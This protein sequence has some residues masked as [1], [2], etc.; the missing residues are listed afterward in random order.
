[1]TQPQRRT[2]S[3]MIEETRAKLVAIARQVF[4]SQ[5]FANTSMDDFTAQVCLTRGALYHHFGNKEGLLIAVIEQIEA[6]VGER[7]QAVSDAAP[8]PWEGFRRRC[9]TYLELALE[10]EIRRIILQD[11]RAVFGDVPPAARSVGVAALQQALDGL[12]AEGSVAPLHTGVTARM[13]YGAVTEASFWIAEPDA[14]IE[15]RLGEALDSLDRLLG[16]LLTR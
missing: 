2:R 13:I 10:P 11:A 3:S 9:R 1:M 6:E 14:E 5:G 15:T 7:L 4:A 16:N 8:T 12:V